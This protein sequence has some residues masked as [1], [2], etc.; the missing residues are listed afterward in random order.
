MTKKVMLSVASVFLVF[1]MGAA[2]AAGPCSTTGKDAGS[3]PTPGYTGATVGTAPNKETSEST[4]H[5]PTDVMNKAAGST[6]TSSEDAQRQ[7]QGKPTAAEEAR[8]KKAARND[9]DC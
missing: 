3:G 6:A 5:P 7:M 9:Q 4:T 2:A 1:G 8:G